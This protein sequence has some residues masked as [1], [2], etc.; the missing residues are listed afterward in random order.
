MPKKDFIPGHAVKFIHGGEEYFHCLEDVI[1]SARHILH[2]QV[3]ILENDPTG[4]KVVEALKRAA[5]RRVTVFLV[6]DGFGSASLGTSFEKEMKDSG[7]HFRFFSPLP[8][9]GL[10]QAGRRLH[11]KVCVADQ[12][13]ALVGGINIADKYRGS[14]EEKPWL[15]YAL[16]AEGPVCAAIHAAC[17]RVYHK[18]FS[19]RLPGKISR[20]DMH[21]KVPG[22]IPVRMMMND[23][24]R[25]KN[26]ISS[27]YKH[28]L[29]GAHREMLV[30]ASYF[31]PTR[32]L[33]K[34]LVRAAKRGKSVSVI[35]SRNS[36]VLLMK[37]A[38]HFL[39]DKLLSNGVRVFEYNESVLHAKVCVV[40]TQWVSVGSHNLNHLSEL[41]SIEMNLEVLDRDFG[42]SVSLE[43][44]ELMR[45]HCTEITPEAQARGSNLI[46]RFGHWLAFKIISLSM[47]LLYLLNMEDGPRR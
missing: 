4:R 28:M 15:D 29:N 43:L 36:D 2:L 7:I 34:I 9:P 19:E 23:W 22:K 46:R 31:I 35:L 16:E 32:R 33:L 39:Y 6:V 13:R 42:E 40:D 1:D 37:P 20:L 45:N 27:S 41:I 3:Y 12:R 11:H 5:G 10:L 38:M 21:E 14:A 44:K 8:F 30:L 24:V 26:E 17:E 47:R 25:R 18:R